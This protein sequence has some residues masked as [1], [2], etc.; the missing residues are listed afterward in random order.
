MKRVAP[1]ILQ[2][3]PVKRSRKG[4]DFW[5][6]PVWA[7]IHI[8]GATFR[9]DKAQAF[10]AYLF[11][12]PDLLPCE[13][14]CEHLKKNLARFGVDNYLVDNHSAF[15][16]TYLLHDS[17]NEQHN[18]HNPGKPPKK[19]PK[20]EDVKEFYFRSLDDECKQCMMH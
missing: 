2:Q 11:L 16:L 4:R 15:L 1:P 13:I 12:L 17:V 20:F 7:N 3:R 10:R 18:R 8:F 19:S 14:C 6:P 9:P 5:G